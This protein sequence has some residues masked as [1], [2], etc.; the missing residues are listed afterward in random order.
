MEILREQILSIFE[1]DEINPE[2]VLRELEF[3]DS[4]SVIS[5]LAVI[6]ESYGINIEATELVDVIT[7]A[8]LFTF[9]EQHRKK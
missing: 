7:I 6:D 2:I 1:I 8:D 5:L 4:L 3:W 9:V